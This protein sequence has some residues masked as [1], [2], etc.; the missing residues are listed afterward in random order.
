MYHSV[1]QKTI[2]IT[3]NRSMSYGL[4]ALIFACLLSYIYFANR[5]VRIVT[6]LEKIKTE[7]Q[8]LSVKVGDLETKRLLFDNSVSAEM[9]KH[10]G[11]VEVNHQT[12]IINKSQK[13]ALSLK[14]D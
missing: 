2:A 10:L 1:R 4:I 6:S 5:A 11:F 12:F 13:S 8:S 9:A 7:V 3:L 14:I